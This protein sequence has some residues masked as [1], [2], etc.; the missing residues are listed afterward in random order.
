[1]NLPAT[2]V[3]DLKVHRGDVVLSTQG[4]SF[5]VLDD[6]G[7]LRD[8]AADIADGLDLRAGPRTADAGSPVR[9][10][11]P[12]DASR[13]RA[14]RPMSEVDLALPDP[15][16]QGALLSYAVM[17]AVE[18]LE[19][20]VTDAQGTIAARWMEDSSLSS[21]RGFHRLP[22]PL[23]YQEAGG[24]KAPP[25]QYTVRLRWDGGSEEH[26]LRVLPNLV[27]PEI[28]AE[29]YQEQ[30]RIS[31]DVQQTASDI[32]DAIARLRDI[33]AQARDILDRARDA[34]RE[35]GNLEALSEAMNDRLSPLEAI[36]TSTDDPTVPTGLARPRGGG[37][38]RDYG[39]LLYYLNSGGGYGAGGTEGRPTAGA[40]DRK[41]DLDAVWADTRARLETALD[42][43]VA[44][45]NAEVSRLG[46]A[47]IIVG[48]GG[49]HGEGPPL[50]P[51][52]RRSRWG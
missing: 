37:L 47:G 16:P 22:W 11:P 17:G 35:L 34:E 41:R 38:G 32:R 40:M 44:L 8:L 20:T 3:T 28:T 25:G 39:T 21:D 13:G 7:P 31:M 23:R 42:E 10:F 15:L 52:P 50:G 18:K 29:D 36:L 5:W 45:F 27:D 49:H 33:Q 30:F 43:E 26:A 2:P 4:R 6:I 46:L 24:I 19:L 14:S 9:L 1:M 51:P 12:R 48:S